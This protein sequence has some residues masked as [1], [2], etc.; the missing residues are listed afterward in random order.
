MQTLRVV[1]LVGVQRRAVIR[2]LPRQ[3]RVDRLQARDVRV[4]VAADLDLEQMQ[5]R[6]SDLLRETA[7]ALKSIQHPDRMPELDLADRTD[8]RQEGSDALLFEIRRLPR[9]D[10]EDIAPQSFGEGE[11]QR[12]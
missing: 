5:P 11:L 8:I 4:H 12:L 2:H 7:L 10:A 1:L 9:I 6:V 3:K